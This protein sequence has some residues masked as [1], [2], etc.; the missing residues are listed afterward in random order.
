[1][2]NLILS[3]A[4][5]AAVFY[6][7]I[8]YASTALV[9]FAFTGIII[10]CISYI[11]QLVLLLSIQPSVSIPISVSEQGKPVDMEIKIKNKSF[12][13]APKLMI[14]L[15]YENIL[16]GERGKIKLS[17]IAD[18]RR[19]SDIS[20]AIR[21][22]SCGKYKIRLHKIRFYD[23]TGFFYLSKRYRKQRTELYIMP[24]LYDTAVTVAE[25]SRHFL[26]EADVYDN[27]AGGTNASE[28]LQI[29]PFR[30]GD[31]IQNIHWKMTAKSDELM[32]RENR[33]PLGCSVVLF[34]DLSGKRKANNAFLSLVST[35]SFALIDQK[36]AHYVTWYSGCEGD[37][38][39]VRVDDEES[40]YL[41][42]MILYEEKPEKEIPDIQEGY[43]KKFKGEP[44]VTGIA[45]QTDLTVSVGDIYRNTFTSAKL[46]QELSEVE[47]IV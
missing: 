25:A 26:G 7:S 11:Y 22:N 47:F 38:I 16:T 41:F 29:R 8:I 36:C 13:P 12:F 4:L 24:E 1:M 44:F 43:K 42:L 40:F 10:M 14:F 31:K 28:I 19:T 17:G 2:I 30:D 23:L 3:L 21:A 35:I 18:F 46:K 34:L 37:V 20:T 33:R 39:R 15:R 5:I 32:V 27:I 45:I 9:F 6:T